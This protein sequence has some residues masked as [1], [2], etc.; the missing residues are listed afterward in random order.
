MPE[1]GV[2]LTQKS[3]L[4]TT[5]EIIQIAAIFVKQGVTKIRLTG[6]EPLVRADLVDIVRALKQLPGLET[7]GATTNALVLSRRLPALQEAGLDALNISLDTLVPA[8]FEFITRRRG[9]DRVIKGIQDALEAGYDPVKVRRL[10][11]SFPAL[12]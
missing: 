12:N 9:H 6:G 5:E 11:R 3:H 10:F 1:E 7:V 4:L 8:K 2:P